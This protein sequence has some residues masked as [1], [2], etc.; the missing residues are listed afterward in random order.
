M[1][2]ILVRRGGKPAAFTDVSISLKEEGS[3]SFQNFSL[4]TNVNGEAQL[5]YI[6]PYLKSTTVEMKA[7]CSK[8]IEVAK[9]NIKVLMSD[10]SVDEGFPASCRRCDF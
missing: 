9:K 8:C 2:D 4:K 10:L 7:E 1:Q 5:L 3:A 6:P